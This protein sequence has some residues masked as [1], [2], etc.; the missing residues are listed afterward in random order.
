MKAKLSN[1]LG[2]TCCLFATLLLGAGCGAKA[3]V[4]QQGN[5]ESVEGALNIETKDAQKGIIAGTF[6]YQG[7][8]IRFDIV[9]GEKNPW[10]EVAFGNGPEYAIDGQLCDDETHFCFAQQAGGHALANVDWVPNNSA[11]NGPDEVRSKK[12]VQT[13]WQLHQKLE[14]MGSA[15]FEGLSEEYQSL[16]NLS[17][18]PPDKWQL[19]PDQLNERT[20]D[21]SVLSLS[22]AAANTY[23]QQFQMWK[24]YVTGTPLYEHSSSYVYIFTSGGSYY[25]SYYTCNHGSCAGASDMN[26]WCGKNYYSRPPTIPFNTRCPEPA[27]NGAMHPGGSVDCCMSQY[28]VLPLVISH[29]CNDDTHLQRDFI[30]LGSTPQN[31]LYCSDLQVAYYAPSCL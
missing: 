3:E 1:T 23:I 7:H 13:E 5:P 9:R 14:Q 21:K 2:I 16:L 15:D 17:N 4:T 8:R 27:S 12:N 18:L 10:Q 20:P 26:Y 30:A 29:V 22:V 11:S 19:S 31:V 24:R 25:S 6:E 28:N